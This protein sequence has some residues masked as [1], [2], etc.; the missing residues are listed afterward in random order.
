M[1]LTRTDTADRALALLARLVP[2]PVGRF[3]DDLPAAS[4]YDLVDVEPLN[5]LAGELIAR[6][7]SIQLVGTGDGFAVYRVR[8]AKDVEQ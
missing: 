8:S 2:I 1:A 4:S 3:P 7:A 5:W 6:R